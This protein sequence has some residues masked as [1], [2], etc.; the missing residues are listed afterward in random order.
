M[1]AAA[2]LVMATAG[3]APLGAQEFVMKFGNQTQNDVQHEFMKVFKAAV[4]KSLDHRHMDRKHDFA[5]VLDPAKRSII[6]DEDDYPPPELWTSARAT[7][8]VQRR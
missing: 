7:L 3:S 1:L 5:S 8:R 6:D 2:V 4:E